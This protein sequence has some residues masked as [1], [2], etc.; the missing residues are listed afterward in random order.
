MCTNAIHPEAA[1]RFSLAFHLFNFINATTVIVVHF[2]YMCFYLM[3]NV[4]SIRGEVYTH[5]LSKKLNE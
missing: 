4:K 1:E 5:S 3:G 2:H